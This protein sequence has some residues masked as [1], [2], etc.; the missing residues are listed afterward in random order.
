MCHKTTFDL[1]KQSEPVGNYSSRTYIYLGNTFAE[2]HHHIIDTLNYTYKEIYHDGKLVLKSYPKFGGNSTRK[3][4]YTYSKNGELKSKISKTEY[5]SGQM[6][7]DSVNYILL[8]NHTSEIWTYNHQQ[9]PQKEVKRMLGDTTYLD[10]YDGDEILY[11]SYETWESKNVKKSHQARNNQINKYIYDVHGELIQIDR[12]EGIEFLETS[13]QI[14][15]SYDDK[16]RVIKRVNWAGKEKILS[17][18]ECI[19]YEE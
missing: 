5:E 3:I 17:F 19:I 6:R 16:N 14:D 4:E 15:I 18:T 7:I 13:L 10:L 12:Y 11:S 2:K 8:D 1:T 9:K